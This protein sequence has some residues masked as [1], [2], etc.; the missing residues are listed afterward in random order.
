[1]AFEEFWKESG[2]QNPMEI[3]GK[4][5]FK[6]EAVQTSNLGCRKLL[7]IPSVEESDK[8]SLRD[9][10]R[11]KN[12]C[13]TKKNEVNWKQNRESDASQARPLSYERNKEY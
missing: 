13:Y 6:R 2:S 11:Q 1:M 7:S 4:K 3:R 10:T 5:C 12:G 9:I 8:H